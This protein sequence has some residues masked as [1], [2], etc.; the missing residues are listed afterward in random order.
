MLLVPKLE[1]PAPLAGNVPQH[2]LTSASTGVWQDVYAQAFF[3]HHSLL[4][5]GTVYENDSG[6]IALHSLA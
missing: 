6:I 1:L 4:S 3:L 2:R 5:F